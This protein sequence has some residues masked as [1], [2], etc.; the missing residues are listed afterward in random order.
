MKYFSLLTLLVFP[1]FS[2]GA[3]FGISP[4][5]AL[6]Q[7]EEASDDLY[8]LGGTVT[9]AGEVFGD[10]NVLGGNIFVGEMIS[11][12]AFLM[13]GTVDVIA[14]VAQDLRI[15]SGKTLFRGTVGE[16]LAVASGDVHVLPASIISGNTFLAAGKAVIDGSVVGDIEGVVG[17]LF[18]NGTVGGD[19]SVTADKIVLGPNARVEGNFDYSASVP[20]VITE[21][22]VIAGETIYTNVDT[23]SRVEQL[24]PTLWGTWIIVKFFV[25]LI[26]ALV[27][28]GIFRAVSF[29]FVRT[30]VEKPLW[31]LVRGFV[32][33]VAAPLAITLTFF[34]FIGI[35]FAILGMTT[36]IA[37]LVLA[38]LFSPIVIGAV[39]Y[40]LLYPALEAS[41]NWKSIVLGV[42]AVMI[43]G[44]L[45]APGA[46]L[47][48]VLFLITLGAIY[49]TL[50]ERFARAR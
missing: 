15:I 32:F 6:R 3:T 4:E 44:V 43:V 48:S 17:D 25:L 26:S 40:R 9:I 8:A 24:V 14:S 1:L 7:G 22:A 38:Y 31:G 50:F 36:Y 47:Q 12:D 28:H 5:Y 16:D 27:I 34:T 18:I 30:A 29:A 33:L 23:R 35:P 21:G 49:Q 37:A 20:V 11:E 19:V 46:I 13:G 2:F 42:C 41:I 10:L 39:I 45:G